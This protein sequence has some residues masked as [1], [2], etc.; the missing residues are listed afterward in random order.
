MSKDLYNSKID[1]KEEM[2]FINNTIKLDKELNELD[3][4]VIKFIKVLEKHS[5]Y[6]IIS[7]Y[8]SIL[9]GRSRATEDID[10]FI[11]ELDK[12]VFIK[13]YKELKKANFW[14][15]NTQDEKEIYDYVNNNTGTT[16][17]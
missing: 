1:N 6:V 14:C 13:L 8:V 9:L 10:I 15:F 4:F 5:D 2:E 3:K 7:G 17:L 11:E 16:Y 12:E